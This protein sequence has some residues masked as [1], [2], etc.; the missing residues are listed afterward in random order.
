PFLI[1]CFLATLFSCY[2]FQ[3]RLRVEGN[4]ELELHVKNLM[5]SIEWES[6]PSIL[7]FGLLHRAEFIKAGQKEGADRNDR[8]LS[9]C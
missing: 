1:R 5:D 7:R 9:P 3:R 6:M 8:A 2:S 4:I